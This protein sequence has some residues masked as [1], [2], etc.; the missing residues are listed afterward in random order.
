MLLYTKTRDL[1]LADEQALT[2]ACIVYL[3]SVA[4]RPFQVV[5]RDNAEFMSPFGVVPFASSTGREGD[6]ASEFLPLV[7]FCSCTQ[8][9]SSPGEAEAWTPVSDA[10]LVEANQRRVD[11]TYAAE[12]FRLV[13]LHLQWCVP[14][15]FNG[16]T[17]ERYGARIPW[18]I[19]L[20]LCHQRRRRQQAALDAAGKKDWTLAEVTSELERL[21]DSLVILLGSGPCFYSQQEPSALDAL[22]F[23]Y[24]KSVEP[25]GGHVPELFRRVAQ[26]EPLMRHKSFVEENFYKA[27][28]LRNE[29][30]EKL[31]RA[32]PGKEGREKEL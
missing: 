9:D 25:L 7:T 8:D 17:Q 27:H 16:F 13:F 32:S 19:G 10:G 21:C 18:P 2:L 20:I 28:R 29:R 3:D 22:V 26:R 12:T 30:V 5:E 31:L 24:L 14:E 4:K 11:L 23:G 6:V 1:L 15:V